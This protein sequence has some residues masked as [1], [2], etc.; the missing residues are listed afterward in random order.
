MWL[1]NADGGP[2]ASFVAGLHVDRSAIEA[3]LRESWSSGQ[4]EAP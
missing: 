2:P 4:V 3:A 1:V